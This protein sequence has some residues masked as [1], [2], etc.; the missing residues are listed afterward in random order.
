MYRQLTHGERYAMANMFQAGYGCREIGR[1][2]GRSA[3]TICR[4]RQRNATRHDGAY[5]PDKAQQYA[6]ARRRRTRKGSQFTRRQWSQVERLLRRKWSPQQI[7]GRRRARGEQTMSKETIYRHV[8]RERRTGGQL[9]KQLR[10][11]SKFGRKRRGSPATRGRLLGKRHISEQ[12]AARA[13]SAARRARP[14]G[15]RHRDGLGHEALRADAGGARERVCRDQEAERTHDGAGQRGAEAGHCSAGQAGQD[16]HAGQRHGVPRLQARGAS[17]RCEVLLRHAVPL[18]G[19]RHQREHQRAAQ[20][21]PAQGYL[22]A[23]A[24]QAP[25]A[26]HI[27]DKGLPTT[28]LLAQVLV[29]KYADHLPLYRQEGI[30]ERAGLAIARSTLAQWVGA[31]GAQLQPLV[32]ALRTEL[33]RLFADSLRAGKRAAAVM[34]LVH[35]A[36]L[37]GR[38]PYAYLK[39]VLERLPTQPAS[40]IDELLPHRWRVP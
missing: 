8:W 1:V 11:L 32:D 3:S 7:V 20:A 38:D 35:S 14:L 33:L 24:V 28:G 17:Q 34:S 25:V 29:A 27:I 36:R 5:R 4:E 16:D 2:L 31:C 40:R 18:M 37:N 6:M 13:G 22:P 19:A 9:W 30:F 21:I 12:R 10:I 26:P 23:R 15:G 39:D